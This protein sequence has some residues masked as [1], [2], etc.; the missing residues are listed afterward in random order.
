[1]IKISAPGKLMLSGE[2]SVLENGIPCIVLAVDKKVRAQIE[3]AEEITVNLKDFKIE[4]KATLIGVKI[5]FEKENEILLFTK[6]A[7]E[8]AL[9]YIQAKGLK[10]KKFRLETDSDISLVEFNSEKMKVGF[11]SSGA[12]VVAIIGAVLKL[13]NISIADDKAKEKLFKLAIMAHY[14]AQ[15]KIGSG[16]DVCASTFGGAIQYRRFDAEWLTE[17]LKIKSVL[18]VVDAKWPGL[19][20]MRIELPYD[21]NLMVGFTGKSASTKE[22]VMK[23]REFKKENPNEYKKIISGIQKVTDGLVFALEQNDHEEIKLLIDENAMLLRMLSNE[24]GANLEIQEHLKMQRIA[25]SNG[26]AAKFSG[27]GGG[28]CS[29]GIAFNPELAARVKREWKEA[30]LMPIETS[31]S[32]K[33]V[34]EEK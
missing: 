4:T 17:Q 6:H 13:H 31:V 7:I 30:G 32:E 18:D 20:I 25:S 2:W 12:A 14:F 24:S 16:F 11:G 22:L 23:I 1:M 28:D 21:F 33:G 29:V 10:L 5:S 3:E 15:G 9:K 26:C 8:T 34:T 19:E 27:A